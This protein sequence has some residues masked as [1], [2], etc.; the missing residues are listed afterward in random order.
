MT[1]R[2]KKLP[3]VTAV[4]NAIKPSIPDGE[5][6]KRQ[7]DDHENAAEASR[8]RLARKADT[9]GNNHILFTTQQLKKKDDYV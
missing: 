5:P 4:Q 3:I 1:Q 9:D 8:P 7:N 2:I 6:P